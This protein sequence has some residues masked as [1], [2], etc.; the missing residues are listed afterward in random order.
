[1]LDQL[2]DADVVMPGDGFGPAVQYL[3]V[4]LGVDEDHRALLW[5]DAE[6]FAFEGRGAALMQLHLRK[7]APQCFDTEV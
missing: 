2:G 1:M 6:P 7:F 5:H 4:I 3:F